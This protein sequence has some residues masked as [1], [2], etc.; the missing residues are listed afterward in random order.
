MNA[1]FSLIIMYFL[2]FIYF[3]VIADNWENNVVM[4]RSYLGM[5]P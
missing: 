2:L 5:Y 4:F 1:Y 3:M